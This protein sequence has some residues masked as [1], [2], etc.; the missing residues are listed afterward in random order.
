MSKKELLEN[1]FDVLNGNTNYVERDFF[2]N[3][4]DLEFD[5][6]NNCVG[7]YECEHESEDE[8]ICKISI[9]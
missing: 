7:I 6:G 1:V 9:K 5:G 2:I 8:H 4:F 3:N